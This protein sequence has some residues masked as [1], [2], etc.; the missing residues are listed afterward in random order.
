MTSPG[1]YVL[2]WRAEL[3]LDGLTGIYTGTVPDHPHIVTFSMTRDEALAELTERLTS[4]PAG[5][6]MLIDKMSRSGF[7]DGRHYSAFG[8]EVRRLKRAGELE[9]VE[10]LLLRLAAA[11]E[12]EAK[13]RRWGVAPWY[14]E[15]LA[16]VYRKQKRQADEIAVLERYERQRKAPGARPAKLAKR[17]AKLQ[18]KTD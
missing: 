10:A 8:D 7:V 18:E 13:A 17:L 9:Q 15:Q 2:G 3:H 16:I 14:Y 1:C 6:D 5:Q 11:T 4:T 12:A